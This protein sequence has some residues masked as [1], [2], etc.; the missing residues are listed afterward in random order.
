MICEICN[1]AIK[2]GD[3]IYFKGGMKH[4]ICLDKENIVWR[5]VHKKSKNEKKDVYDDF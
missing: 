3:G 4:I 5:K 2:V 1:K